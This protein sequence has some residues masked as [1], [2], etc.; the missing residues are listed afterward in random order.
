MTRK[1]LTIASLL[2]VL[3]LV[4]TGVMVASSLPADATLPVHWGL[5]GEADRFAD[6]WTALLLPSAITAVVSTLFFFLPSVEP[7]QQGL[8][9]SRGLYFWGWSAMLLMAVAIQFALV[10]EALSWDV[11]ASRVIAG[12]LGVLL[13]LTGNQLGKSRS[14]YTVGIRT[15]WTLASEDVWIKTHRLGGKLMVAAGLVSVLASALIPIHVLTPIMLS[16]VAIVAIV[17][18]GYSYLLWRRGAAV[19]GE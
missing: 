15:P 11:S 18:V 19:H 3:A 6:K 8:E 1:I 16:S 17:P 12:S 14:M 9:R 4:G 7:R 2:V 13:I 10:S 5:D